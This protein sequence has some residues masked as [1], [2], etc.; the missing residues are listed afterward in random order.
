M[1]D[2]VS[3]RSDDI[4]KKGLLNTISDAMYMNYRKLWKIR[5]RSATGG[6]SIYEKDWDILV[7]L[8]A[9]R[10]DLMERVADDYSFLN[11]SGTAISSGSMS[12]EWLEANFT[13]NYSEQIERTAYVTGNPFSET[14]ADRDFQLLDEVWRYAW[15]NDLG[16]IPPRPLTD[17]AISVMREHDPEY[18]IVHYMQPHYPFLTDPELHPGIDIDHFNNHSSRDDI[19]RMLRKGKVNRDRVEASYEQNL[20]VVLDDVSLLLDN[21]N[22]EQVVISSDHGN[23][24]GEYG[25]YG[26]PE[27]ITMDVIRRVP[28]YETS[29]TDTKQHEPKSYDKDRAGDSKPNT[30]DVKRRLQDLGY[31]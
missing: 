25:I 28:W 11:Q 17:R 24:I 16:T 23:A 22:A 26:H 13:E 18:L 5:G 3:A 20:R 8:D 14:V 30:S 19:W 10:V 7:V 31:Y 4:R 1:K 21:V 27:G 9:C 15:E 12:R 2:W 29:A 6:E